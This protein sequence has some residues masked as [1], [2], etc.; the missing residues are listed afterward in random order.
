MVFLGVP[1]TPKT[2]CPHAHTAELRPALAQAVRDDV[3]GGQRD[4]LLIDLNKVP[5]QHCDPFW[6]ASPKGHNNRNGVLFCKSEIIGSQDEGPVGERFFPQLSSPYNQMHA[7]IALLPLCQY[8]GTSCA[9]ARQAT[10]VYVRFPMSWPSQPQAC[11]AQPLSRRAYA[12]QQGPCQIPIHRANLQDCPC[13]PAAC[14]APN[15][16]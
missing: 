1:L 11:K 12:S 5:M 14:S 7:E 13:P 3:V 16:Q 9:V 6:M 4:A 2:G 15:K 8:E 10:C